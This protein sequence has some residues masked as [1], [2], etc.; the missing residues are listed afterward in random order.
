MEKADFDKAAKIARAAYRLG[1]EMAQAPEAP[2]KIKAGAKEKSD[3][4]ITCSSLDLE[5]ADSVCSR[6]YPRRRV[7]HLRGRSS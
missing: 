1:Y 6:G 2:K 3:P 4:A 5:F 7:G